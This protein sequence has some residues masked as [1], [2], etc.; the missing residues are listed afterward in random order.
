LRKALESETN[1]GTAARLGQGCIGRG[2]PAAS[3]SSAPPPLP[4]GRR[5]SGASLAAGRFPP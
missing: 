5:G 2:A 1:S 3:T 4:S